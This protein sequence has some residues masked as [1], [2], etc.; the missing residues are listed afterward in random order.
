MQK[1][2]IENFP[3]IAYGKFSKI[4]TSNWLKKF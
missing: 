4:A 2:S 1:Y 3:L